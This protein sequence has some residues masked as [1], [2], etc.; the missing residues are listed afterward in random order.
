LASKDQGGTVRVW[1]PST[2]KLLRTL[3]NPPSE[4]GDIAVNHDGR[5]LAVACP[6]GAVRLWDPISGWLVATLTG[7]QGPARAV[8]FLPDGHTLASSGQTD[9]TIRLWDLTTFRQN[10]VLEG[11]RSLAVKLA[12]RADGRLLVSEDAEAGTIRLWDPT[13]DPARS[14][15]I[16]LFPPGKGL[17]HS[18]T[19]TPEGRY[20]ATANPDGTVYFLRLAERGT[21]YQVPPDLSRGPAR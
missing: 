20:L 16:Q 4:W 14:Q 19:L 9:H 18:V 5:L 3:Q 17:L 10:Q 1:D 21:V 13:V 8:L 15:A 12:C 6:D 11:T 2:G 7:H